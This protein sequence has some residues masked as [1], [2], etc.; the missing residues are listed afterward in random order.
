MMKGRKTMPRR[1]YGTRDPTKNK[2]TLTMG[3]EAIN[4]ENSNVQ[5]VNV[6][7]GNGNGSGLSRDGS[8]AT[9]QIGTEPSPPIMTRDIQLENL[10]DIEQG[11]VAYPNPYSET[12]EDKDEIEKRAYA[13]LLDI[14]KGIIVN[15]YKSALNIIDQSG[16]VILTIDDLLSILSEILNMNPSDI[17]VIVEDTV[18]ESGCSCDVS[19]FN[20]IK[21]VS[22]IMIHKNN[23]SYNFEYTYNDIYNKMSDEFLISLDKVIVNKDTIIKTLFK[24]RVA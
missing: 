12:P 1:A 15:D 16:L 6:S 2:I 24:K 20:P 9:I 5:N 18:E 13:K 8:I 7:V 23:A 17:D 14:Y 4:N 10:A 19:V 3:K 22:S 21:D 11:K